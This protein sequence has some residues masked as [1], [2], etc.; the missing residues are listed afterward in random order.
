[1]K[2]CIL[3]DKESDNYT[4]RAKANLGDVYNHYD[5]L[6]IEKC[7]KV[8]QAFNLNARRVLDLGCAYGG[9]TYHLAKSFPAAQF[10]GVDPGGETIKFAR[11]NVRGSNISFNQAHALPFDDATFDLIILNM[12]LQWIPRNYLARTIAEIER[13]LAPNGVI[14][15]QEFLPDRPKYSVTA[16][17]DQICIFKD[18]YAECFTSFPWLK[19][20]Y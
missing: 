20:I 8:L 9:F 7:R 13:V 2:D 19:M 16:H 14:F 1:M 11:E 15:V 4:D 6:V 18:N 10:T 12:V 5:L 17:N 3:W